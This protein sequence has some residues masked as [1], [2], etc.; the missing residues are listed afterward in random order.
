MNNDEI[1]SRIDG[2]LIDK[3]PWQEA[4]VLYLRFGLR[5]G[6]KRTTKEVAAIMNLP[7]ARVKELEVQGLRAMGSGYND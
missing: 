7:L 3:M 1:Q 6:I 5:D 2:K 4:E